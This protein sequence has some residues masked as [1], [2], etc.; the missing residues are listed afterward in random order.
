MKYSEKL[1]Q[2]ITAENFKKARE[3]F[4]NDGIETSHE[5]IIEAAYTSG[6]NTFSH[7]YEFLTESEPSSPILHY[8]AAEL[9]TTVFN[10]LPEGYKLAF[11]HAKKSIE[12]S[13]DDITYKEFI[14][15]F[16]Q[17]P[18]P[19]L[20]KEDALRYAG[21]IL[22]KDPSNQAANLFMRNQ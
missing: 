21:E 9:Y 16:Y 2:E 7:F 8:C 11:E 3:I 15:L 10:Y 5:K 18:L 17:L 14:L 22:T 20:C 4:F 19:L 13:G 1:L 12:L 6:D